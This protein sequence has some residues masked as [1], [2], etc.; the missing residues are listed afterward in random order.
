[1]VIGTLLESDCLLSGH[2][3][4]V[5]PISDQRYETG[6]IYSSGNIEIENMHLNIQNLENNKDL[7]SSPK[8]FPLGV[9]SPQTLKLAA[10][11]PSTFHGVVSIGSLKPDEQ[12]DLRRK[13]RDTCLDTI[14]Y[15]STYTICDPNE[16]HTLA[17]AVVC[18][19]RR[20]HK[21]AEYE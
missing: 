13:I 11:T 9:Q 17:Y 16:Y 2:S 3:L 8:H 4:S 14:E 19:A 15:L 1:M 12:T 21:I 18:F 7:G 10:T 5:S 6:P 20:T